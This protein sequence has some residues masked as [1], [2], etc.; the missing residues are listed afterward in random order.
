[1]ER[2]EGDANGHVRCVH[3]SDH[4]KIE[5]S[6]VFVALGA[7]PNVEWLAESGLAVG[8]HG[9]ACDAGC[10]AFDR[11]GIATDDVY[12]A[13]DVARFPHPLFDFEFVT[14]EH[15]GNAVAMAEV[16]AHNMLKPR[17]RPRPHIGVPADDRHRV[18]RN[19]HSECST[20]VLLL[21]AAN[22]DRV[23]FEAAHQFDP[24]RRDNQH[25]G[26]GSGV[27]S[28][29]GAPLARLEGQIA[30]RLF[31][32]RVVNPRLVGEPR[33][34]P[35]PLLRGPRELIIACNGVRWRPLC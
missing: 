20:V 9:I 6:L 16:A 13:G 18:G 31:F 21:A 23:Q 26:F 14:L 33:Y 22:R 2:L 30:L 24:D 32:E 5:A 19:D 17:G 15:W 11:F 1:V 29:F 25:L 4:D 34:R 10:R 7:I 28:C 3:L 8:P 12:V 35:S 27:H